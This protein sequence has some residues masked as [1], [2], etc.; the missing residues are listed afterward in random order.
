MRND[1]P[2]RRRLPRVPAELF[3]YGSLT[4]HEVLRSILRR[5]PG[6]RPGSARGWRVA[7]V[8]DRVYPA[9]V[10][11]EKT[12]HGLVLTDLSP[13]EWDL[14]DRFEAP[15]YDLVEIRLTDGSTAWTYV[16]GGTPDR[17][18]DDDWDRDRFCA[19]EL[20]RYLEL[21][22]AW[23]DSVRSSAPVSEDSP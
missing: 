21:T 13:T 18:S 12:V 8:R 2:E 11:G 16:W 19:D 4:V 3:V 9:L 22:I 5:E 1:M 10:A 23:C 17:I 20:P 14:L 6:T 7:A 15:A